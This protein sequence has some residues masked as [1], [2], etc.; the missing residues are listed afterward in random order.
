MLQVQTAVESGVITPVWANRTSHRAVRLLKAQKDDLRKKGRIQIDYL[1]L[2]INA[3]DSRR[4]KLLQEV[5]PSASPSMAI[6]DWN[7]PPIN[8]ATRAAVHTWSS[9][10]PCAAGPCSRYPTRLLRTARRQ[11]A[12]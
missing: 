6:G 2:I 7:F 1:G 4:G 10:Q 12:W 5:Q 3:Y 11:T 8:V 9:A